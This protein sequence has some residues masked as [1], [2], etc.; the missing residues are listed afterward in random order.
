MAKKI[1]SPF[2]TVYFVNHSHIDH[3]WWN[4]PEKCR[5]RNEEILN[6][7][8][9]IA[10]VEPDFKFSYE[11]TAAL[12]QYLEKYPDRKEEIHKLLQQR[13][14]DI[15]GMFVSANDD[16]CSAEAIVR[17]FLYG[18]GWLKRTFDYLPKIAKEFDTPG[19]PSQLPQLIHD[20]GMKALVITRGP[21]GGFYWAGP[22]GSEILTFCVPYNWSFWRRLGASYE[23]TEKNLPGELE[24]AARNFLGPDLVIPDGDDMTL[25][26]AGLV[27]ICKE[28][29][30]NY[31][32]PKLRLGTFE[33]IIEIFGRRRFVRRQ[34]EM[35]N[36]WVVIHSVQAETT[37]HL[38]N[39]QNILPSIETLCSILSA[40]RGNYRLYPAAGIDSL[41]QKCLLV[42]DHNWGGKDRTRH[43]A[44]GDEY[45]RGLMLK[46]LRE[47][48]EHTENAFLSFG[49]MV[50]TKEPSLG[51]PVLVFNPCSWERREVVS[52]DLNCG[53]TGLQD[54]E[55]VNAEGKP[56]PSGYAVVERHKDGSIYRAAC[57][58][59]GDNVP[60]IGYSAFYIKPV[61]QR[62]EDSPAEREGARTIENEF[63]RVTL[64]EDGSRIESLYDKE[65][66]K[67]LACKS[68]ASL[69]PVEFEFGTFELFGIG[70]KLAVPDESYFENP[71]NEG[72]GETVEPTGDIFRAADA[73]AKMRVSSRGN[74]SLTLTAEAEFAGALRR[75]S[76]VLYHG[77]KRIDLHVELDWK[78]KSNVAVFLQM[79]TALMNGRKHIDVPFAA[80][81]DGN[82]LTDFWV[83]ENLP[84]QFKIRGVQDWLTFEDAGYG[85]A[86]A[87]RWPI[88]D[89]TAVPA[90]PLLWTNDDSG[91]FFGER[92]QQKG[93]HRF[94]FSLTSYKGSWPENGIHRWGKGWARPLLSYSG[95]AAPETPRHSYFSVDAPN[96]I[97]STIKKANDED[98]LVVR[99]YEACGKKTESELRT[100]FPIKEA[101]STNIIETTSKK[102][103]ASGNSVKLR[104]GPYEIKTIKLYV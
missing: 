20:A 43:G 73:P 56:V 104:F 54:I 64:A 9:S 93:N 38:K 98:A 18:A 17:N 100:S 84:V 10:S 86:F 46:S 101:Q 24:R 78:G 32:K 61:F 11:T 69:G 81:T 58:F 16:V 13:R 37:R 35:P 4:S 60:S 1:D 87:S 14:L 79:P 90:F 88:I 23:E 53:I 19:H 34:G 51:M 41:W 66:G 27:E 44:E 6:E 40:L 47:L 25:P 21:Q 65:F 94:S 83:D 30:K 99:L 80:H 102:L 45:K 3:T 76:V 96:V 29:N 48:R 8:L 36:L 26:N 42:A 55:I 57:E 59:L 71:E 85:I 22:D 62:K 103:S 15:G 49:K 31:D 75:Q 39:L 82:E 12:I 5:E 2:D 68:A 97:I 91:F 89:L 77:L 63:Y 67:E 74:L 50:M 95:D 72:T 70:L 33:E 7:L 28:W 92:Y 52:L